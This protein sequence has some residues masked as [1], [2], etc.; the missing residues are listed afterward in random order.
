[1]SARHRC[2]AQPAGFGREL[3]AAERERQFGQQQ[4]A[5]GG[6]D[7]QVFLESA[8]QFREVDVQ[9]HHD[10]QEQHRDGADIDDDQDQREELG[11]GDQEQ[12]RRR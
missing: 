8:A 10:E 3:P 4:H 11:T 12:A 5:D 9:H 1:M 7:R 2:E 6:A